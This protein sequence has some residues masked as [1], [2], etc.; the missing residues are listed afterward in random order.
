MNKKILSAFILY[1]Y[2]IGYNKYNKK[3]NKL[4]R[5]TISFNYAYE[6]FYHGFVVGVLSNMDD[7]IVKS[8]RESG[9]GRSDIFIKSVSIFDP[10]VIIELKVCDN[11]KD[12]FKMSDKALEQIEEKRYEDE[13]KQEGYENIIKY[14]ISFYRK[15][16]IIKLQK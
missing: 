6:N 13:L 1:K 15:D 14:G 5:E 7:Y 4:L 9:D 11:P 16:C 2:I 12:I 8:N 10:A 3:L